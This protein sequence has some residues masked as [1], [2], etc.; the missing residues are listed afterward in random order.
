MR[1]RLGKGGFTLAELLI[2][3]AVI[4]VLS[5]VSITVYADRLEHSRRAADM[6]MMRSAKSAIVLGAQN[7]T[8]KADGSTKYFYDSNTNTVSQTQPDQGYGKSRTSAGEWWDGGGEAYGVPNSDGD[9]PARLALTITKDGVVN[10]YWNGIYGGEGIKSASEYMALSDQEKLDKDILLLNSLQA[11]LRSMTF[12]QLYEMLMNPNGK[13]FQ[14]GLILSRGTD[15]YLCVTLSYSTVS[16]DGVITTGK[17]KTQIF[18]D[19]IF[20]NAGYDTSVAD[21]NKYIVNS[22][23]TRTQTI[24]ANLR[25]T[26]AELKKLSPSDPKWTQLAGSVYTYV[27]S[28]GLKTPEELRDANRK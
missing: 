14:N 5:A 4:A 25:I 24:W 15:G 19:E 6:S 16:R 23:P 2:V 9:H 17:G 1:K 26:E 27:K 12:G 3:V 20:R 13:T 7:G 22:V 11:E 10:Y 28:D 21:E 8:V 18:F